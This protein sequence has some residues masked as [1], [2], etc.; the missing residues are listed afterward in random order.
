MDRSQ[1]SV[2]GV[3]ADL[4]P[5]AQQ[6]SSALTVPLDWFRWLP[7][8]GVSLFQRYGANGWLG[9]RLAAGARLP[10]LTMN[11]AG[12]VPVSVPLERHVGERLAAIDRIRSSEQ[13]SLRAGWLFV[14]GRQ[15]IGGGRMQRVFSPL[16]SVPVRIALPP[17]LGNAAVTAAGDVSISELVTDPVRRHDLEAAYELGGGALDAVDTAEIPPGCWAGSTA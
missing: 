5:S 9:D 6:H 1:A 15:P 13:R 17:L 10:S 16:L 8:S 14:A 3:L 2:L 7:A 12:Q 4:S 11:P